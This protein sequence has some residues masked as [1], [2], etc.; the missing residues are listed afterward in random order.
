MQF[1]FSLRYGRNQRRTTQNFSVGIDL[2]GLDP[3]SNKNKSEKN[4]QI[5]RFANLSVDQLQQILAERHSLGTKKVTSW[6]LST[7]KGK[8]SVLIVVLKFVQPGE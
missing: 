6:S 5:A 1:S 3:I 8:I 4:S 7:F 2:L